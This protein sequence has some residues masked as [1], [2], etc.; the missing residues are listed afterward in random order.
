M[1]NLAV[2]E[3]LRG[4]IEQVDD[5]ILHLRV[6]S[7]QSNSTYDEGLEIL[8]ANLLG[9]C[10]YPP[11]QAQPIMVQQAPQKSSGGGSGCLACCA[12]ALCCCCGACDTILHVSDIHLILPFVACSRR[13]VL[14]HDVLRP[15]YGWKPSNQINGCMSGFAPLIIVLTIF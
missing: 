15:G 12:G 7:W 14:R 6:L 2:S 11:Q 5:A 8:T 13:N 3:F 10:S 4:M 1:L 9:S